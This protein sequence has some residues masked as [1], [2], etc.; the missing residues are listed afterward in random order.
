MNNSFQVYGNNFD[1]CEAAA[2]KI[3]EIPQIVCDNDV[4]EPSDVDD[5]SRTLRR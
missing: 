2:V 5:V 4:T 3:V 1:G